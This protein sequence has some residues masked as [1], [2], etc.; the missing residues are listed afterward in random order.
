MS[1]TDDAATHQDNSNEPLDYSGLLGEN[2]DNAG[3]DTSAG[4]SSDKGSESGDNDTTGDEIDLS[5]VDTETLKNYAD[6]KIR[7]QMGEDRKRFLTEL[8]ENA[9]ERFSQLIEEDAAL[10]KAAEKHGI[11][12][13]SLSQNASEKMKPTEEFISL[14]E[15]NNLNKEEA[16]KAFEK[17]KELRASGLSPELAIKTALEHF[18]Q[19]GGMPK[20]VPT[21]GGSAPSGDVVGGKV[22]V[23]E[24]ASWSADKQRIYDQ[25][26]GD[27]P[28]AFLG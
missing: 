24:Y 26:F 11:T 5:K 17:A 13:E 8:A 15:S 22:T 9:P 25:K 1:S 10:R 3:D 23:T 7:S 21:Q 4:D 19:N 2:A 20:N 14:A 6:G 12:P 16:T 28:N 18:T 27:R